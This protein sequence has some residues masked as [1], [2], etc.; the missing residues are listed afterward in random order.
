MKRWQLDFKMRLSLWLI[1][2]LFTVSET[3]LSTPLIIY[4]F[5]LELCEYW[6]KHSSGQWSLIP[7]E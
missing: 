5:I 4:S 6:Q 3:V 7:N 1:L 2:E